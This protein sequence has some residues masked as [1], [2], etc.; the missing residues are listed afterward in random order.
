MEDNSSFCKS[1]ESAAADCR[2]GC[3]P[4][5]KEYID[6]RDDNPTP[7]FGKLFLK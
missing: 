3:A 4:V 6:R 5:K 1:T 7:S 2:S